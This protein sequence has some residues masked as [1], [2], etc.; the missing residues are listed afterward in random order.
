MLDPILLAIATLG[1]LA[2]T[3]LLLQ[4]ALGE[5]ALLAPRAV[6]ACGI[7]GLAAHA[8]LL[9]L[10]TLLGVPMSTHFFRALSLVAW[11]MAVVMTAVHAGSKARLLLAMI[12]PI[13]MASA[14]AGALAPQGAVA[15]SGWQIRLHVVI[16]LSAYA[17]LSIAALQALPVACQ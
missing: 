2:G 11:A 1:Y 3:W 7:A 9:F 4:G 17:L 10:P 8:A 15:I 16:A 13:A 6:L 14:I 5:R 12:W